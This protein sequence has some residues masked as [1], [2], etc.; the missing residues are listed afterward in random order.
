MALAGANGGGAHDDAHAIGDRELLHDRTQARALFGILDL[1]R[2]TKLLGVGHEH[3]VAACQ[4]DVGSNAWTF[5]ADGALGDLDH[6][7]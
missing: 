1:T 4:R 2:D 6:N 5:G 3:K 7:F